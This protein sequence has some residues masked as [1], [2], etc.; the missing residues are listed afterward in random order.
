MLHWALQ[1][2][3]H[4]Y[5]SQPFCSDQS[6]NTTKVATS[7][8]PWPASDQHCPIN[9]STSSSYSSRQPTTGH[10]TPRTVSALLAYNPA[11][12]CKNWISKMLST[13]FVLTSYSRLCWRKCQSCT[14]LFDCDLPQLRHSPLTSICCFR[15][16]TCSR[17]THSDHCCSAHRR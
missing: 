12:V 1:G 16:K 7:F 2:F 8:N 10:P 13:W 14:R 11:K 17:A 5:N 15:T 9:P 6:G 4:C 3:N